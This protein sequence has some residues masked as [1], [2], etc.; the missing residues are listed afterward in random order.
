M[1]C[2]CCRYRR[3]C[4]SYFLVFW[5]AELTA[6]A[7]KSQIKEPISIILELLV[8]SVFILCGVCYSILGRNELWRIEK[9]HDPWRWRGATHVFE[10]LYSCVCRN[11]LQDPLEQKVLKWKP[12]E[13]R[14]MTELLCHL[15]DALNKCAHSGKHAG[16]VRAL[17]L[18][19]DVQK[20]NKLMYKHINQ[21]IPQFHFGINKGCSECLNRN[22]VL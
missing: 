18:F 22:L 5:Y 12:P 13:R 2:F 6:L 16:G 15:D 21:W 1:W 7:L 11:N 17:V 9:E 19:P 10:E 20:V 8:S 3:V 4:W 14:W